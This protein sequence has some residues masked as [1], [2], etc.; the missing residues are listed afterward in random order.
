MQVLAYG[1]SKAFCLNTLRTKQIDFLNLGGVVYCASLQ[2]I[3]QFQARQLV[4]FQILKF[5]VNSKPS[6]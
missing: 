3:L 2:L 5:D 6:A 4:G 1:T